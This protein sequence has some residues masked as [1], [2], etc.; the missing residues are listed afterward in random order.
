LLVVDGVA[1]LTER[2]LAFES[3]DVVENETYWLGAESEELSFDEVELE[4]VEEATESD[5]SLND[6]DNSV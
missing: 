4:S 1:G 6:D 5:D 2:S 3:A